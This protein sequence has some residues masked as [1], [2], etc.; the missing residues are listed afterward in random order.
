[1]NLNLIYGGVGTGKTKRCIEQIEKVVRENPEDRAIM[2]IPDQYSYITD[3]MLVEHFGGTGPNR[4]EAMTFSQLFTRYVKKQNT[5]LTPAG[6]QMLFY[7]ASMGQK[8]KKE[9]IFKST[10]S[11]PGFVEKIADLIGEF[12]RYLIAPEDLKSAYKEGSKNILSLKLSS[13]WDIYEEYN[14]LLEKGFSDSEDDYLRLAEYILNS[15]EWGNTH[16]WF[17]GFSDYLPQHYIVINALL[18]KTKNVHITIPAELKNSLGEDVF[19]VVKET[20]SKLKKMANEVGAELSCDAMPSVCH[21]IKSPELLHLMKNWDDRR[22]SYQ[23]PVE[24]ISVFVAKDMYSEAEYVARKIIEEVKSGVDFKDISVVAVSGDNYSHLFEAIFNDYNIPYFSD[25]GQPITDHPVILTVLGIFDIIEENWGYE[26]VFKYLRTGFVYTKKQNEIK[27]LDKEKIDALENYVLRHGIRGKKVWLQDEKWEEKASGAF[28]SVLG[29]EKRVDNILVVD[30]IRRDIIAPFV[31]FYDKISGKKTAGELAEALYRFLCDINLY[32]AIS[33][34][35]EML[36]KNGYPN[37]SEKVKEIWNMLMEVINQIVV[38][39]GDE[40]CSREDFKNLLSCGLSAS[41]MQIIPSGLDSVL[42]SQSDRN[43]SVNSKVVFFVGGISGTM[44]NEIHTTGILTD[45][46]RRDLKEKGIEVAK[47]NIG[48]AEQ[49]MF[50]FYRAVTS[51]TEK[52]YFSYPT[53]DLE[54]ESKQPSAFLKNLGKMFP[55]M[56]V[57]DDFNEDREEKILSQKQGFLYMLDAVNDSSKK[58]NIK[59]VIEYFNDREGFLDKVNMARYAAQYKKQQPSITRENAKLLYNDYH[60]YSTS[61]LSDYA[62]C[63]FSYFIKHGMKAEE[64]QVWQIQKFE[65]GSL[66]HWA[67]CEYS[68]E[69]EK[70][71]EDF[72]EIKK[73]WMELTKEESSK[74]AERIMEDISERVL[75]GAFKNQ[76]KLA[77]LLRRMK[78]ILLRSVEIVR[79]SLSQGEYTAVCYEEQFRIDIEWNNKSVGLNGTI[80]RVDVAPDAETGTISL[81]I[82]D[83]K[84]GKKNFDVVSISNGEDMQ[85]LVYAIAATELYKKNALGKAQKGLYP[86]V[87]GVLYSKLKNDLVHSNT[88]DTEIVDNEHIKAMRMNGV[89]VSDG[90]DIEAARSMDRN[91]TTGGARSEFMNLALNKKGDSLDSRYSAV[92]P[93]NK[94]DILLSYVRKTVVRLDN[95][96]FSGNISI[97]PNIGKSESSCRYCKYSEICMFD[98]NID[99][100]RKKLESKD[101]AWLYMEENLKEGE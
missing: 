56:A 29:E 41:V 48:K 87:G 6:K 96:I 4:L 17:D 77:Y 39:M 18:R 13:I 32:D 63:P 26:S 82:I 38:I 7:L 51:A 100:S 35:A 71:I 60:R 70:D 33:I 54:G 2:I 91:L 59:K 12:K 25:M 95:E 66:L 16:I 27:E 92:E 81:R 67:V 90:D 31:S 23:E 20:E 76:G 94:F 72:S 21:T 80:D 101:D 89:V 15:E 10:Y 3:K 47:D 64:Q 93:R 84:S 28:D 34:Q 68:K 46:D 24:N 37:E 11:K 50:K 58:E 45:K 1:M 40:Y 69:V 55:N 57:L 8:N 97:L 86:T 79:L 30:E 14:R 88:T 74:I 53:T 43:S 85:L 83:Y 61:R 99:E 52:I 98:K 9:S 5:Y 49:E 62:A 36:R 22:K 75:M 78:K 19:S 42:L 73:R 44:P 65:I